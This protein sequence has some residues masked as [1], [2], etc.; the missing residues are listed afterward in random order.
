MKLK[1]IYL[2]LFALALV[3]LSSCKKND[4]AEETPA[5]EAAAAETAVTQA[6][7]DKAKASDEDDTLV[8]NFYHQVEH[9]AA[10]IDILTPENKAVQKEELQKACNSLQNINDT[11]YSSFKVLVVSSGSAQ[12]TIGRLGE[13]AYTAL[14]AALADFEAKQQANPGVYDDIQPLV[15]R[16]TDIVNKFA[17]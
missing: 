3:G 9:A 11:F 4:A 15:Q 13:T 14:D 10:I 5:A 6:D 16:L 17:K 12:E 1:H 8:V 7:M 2:P